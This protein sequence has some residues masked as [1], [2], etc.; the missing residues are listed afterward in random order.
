MSGKQGNFKDPKTSIPVRYRCKVGGEWKPIQAFSKNQQRLVERQVGAGGKGKVDAANSGMT[1]LEHSA[2]FRSE[3][4]CDLCRLVKP[5]TEFSKSMRKMDDPAPIT[6]FSAMGIHDQTPGTSSSGRSSVFDTSSLPP[7]LAKT[8][9]SCAKSLKS[10]E[11]DA[12][13]RESSTSSVSGISSQRISGSDGQVASSVS[14][15][16]DL[17]PHIRGILG[18]NSKS[19]QAPFV[20]AFQG[21]ATFNKSSASISTATTMRE[22]RDEVTFNA[23][24]NSGH[25]HE[26]VK[27][28]T[29]RSASSV[30]N[31]SAADAVRASE[32]WT[33]VPVK[34]RKGGWHKAPRYRPDQEV[35]NQ[36]SA[37][38]LDFGVDYQR[39][40]NYGPCEDSD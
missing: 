29:D 26:S 28:P 39:R 32:E 11:S 36:A 17:P 35:S 34:Q 13:G 15:L 3:L 30:S 22:A 10:P 23:W 20:G 21:R 37:R 19:G 38:H 12:G 40:L 9:I 16:D 27:V 8:V 5:H 33:N 1:C 14:A 6:S 4:R 2:A 31:D 18:Q 24:D 25:H 7:H